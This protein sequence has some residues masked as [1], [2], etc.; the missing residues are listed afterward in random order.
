MTL[1][2]L[3]YLVALA[4]EGSFSRAADRCAVS[5]PTLSI[6]IA[7]LEE[8]LGVRLFERAKAGKGAVRPMPVGTRVVRQAEIA[9]REAGRIREIAR[10]SGDPLHGP[11]RLGVIHTVR[12]YLLPGLIAELKRIAPEMPLVIEENMT[13]ALAEMLRRDEIDLA[14]IALPFDLPGVVTRALY[15]EPFLVVAPRG[16]RWEGRQTIEP[17]E[18]RGD[19]VL[20]LKA[21]NCFRDQVLGA[22]PQVSVAETDAHLGYSIGTLR[23]MV[24]SG[25]GVTI[26]PASAMRAPYQNELVVTLPFAE[27]KPTRRIAL[28]WRDGFPRLAAVDAIVTAVRAAQHE[29]VA[30]VDAD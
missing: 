25:L 21:G 16:H 30:P 17:S 28:A 12:P 22:C 1:V 8:Q 9:L 13:S 27:P 19:E 15:D 11:L 26:L 7:R 5:Q 23:L 10:M 18:V 14:V 24:A 20:L 6:A 2:E 3:R 29:D 4:A